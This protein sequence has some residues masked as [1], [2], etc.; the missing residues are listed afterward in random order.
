M[1]SRGGKDVPFRVSPWL[2]GCFVLDELG[3]CRG[4]QKQ[5][6]EVREVVHEARGA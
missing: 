1:K 2:V 4:W 3:V 6:E 5:D